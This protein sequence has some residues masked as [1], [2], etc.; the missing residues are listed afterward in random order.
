VNVAR[1]VQELSHAEF[2]DL[3]HV[4]GSVDLDSVRVEFDDRATKAA[5][6]SGLVY[7]DMQDVQAGGFEMLVCDQDGTG[8]KHYSSAS[9]YS[10]FS[11][12][13]ESYLSVSNMSL[14]GDLSVR[15][16]TM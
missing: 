8:T 5:Q 7:G 3:E 15:F 10:A 14:A 12:S 11:V 13:M 16:W 2:A 9:G 6:L 4:P 1:L